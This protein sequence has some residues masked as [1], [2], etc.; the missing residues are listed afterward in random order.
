M[1]RPT[2]RSRRDGLLYRACA[3]ASLD[4][5]EPRR[6]LASVGIV[7]GVLT[8]NADGTNDVINI[9]PIAGGKV[10]VTLNGGNT[11][12][13]ATAFAKI[14]VNANGGNDKVSVSNFL[15]KPATL[16]G[17]PGNDTLGGGGANDVL[18][19]GAGADLIKG[20]NG[21]DTVDYSMRTKPL[22]LGLGSIADDGETGEHDNLST[23]LETILG[24]SAGDGI[25]TR[26]GNQRIVGGGG[27]DLIDTGNGND[28]VD[29]GAGEDTIY[30]QAGNDSILGGAGND[31][32]DAGAGTDFV[33]AQAD[34]G[35][36]FN[37]ENTAGDDW[38]IALGADG[39]LRITGT[40]RSEIITAHIGGDAIIR[41]NFHTSYAVKSFSAAS[42]VGVVLHGNG[43]DDALATNAPR[44]TITGG[45][46]N[47][48]INAGNGPDSIDGG[49]GNDDITTENGNDTVV[50]G[51]GNDSVHAGGGRDSVTGG[52]GNDFLD[53]GFDND[54]IRGGNGD[55]LIH[56]GVGTDSVVGDAGSDFILSG[57]GIGGTE[58]PIKMS[59]GTMTILGSNAADYIFLD[60][61][62]ITYNGIDIW[63]STLP[64]TV[65]RI[66]VQARGGNDNVAMGPD[67]VPVTLDGGDGNDWLAGGPTG[68]SILG[69][70]GNDTLQG[71]EGNDT[72]L[73]GAG[74]D[75]ADG[76]IYN[77]PGD[78]IVGGDG[79][80]I[81]VNADNPGGNESPYT[82]V[83]GVLTIRGRAAINDQIYAGNIGFDYNGITIWTNAPPATRIVILGLGGDDGLQIEGSTSAQLEGGDGNDS[84]WGGSGRNTVLGGNG[85]DSV[86]GGPLKDTIDGGAGTDTLFI[87]AGGDVLTS[88]E[89]SVSS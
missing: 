64:A 49:A 80:D 89:A 83:N 31:F 18:D 37:A 46:G 23:D 88:I 39:I 17:G 30:S 43:G 54:T 7:G 20:G 28:T 59:G 27:N 55:D 45:D 26:D 69:G 29:A 22:Q 74:D 6:L 62:R 47:D 67:F 78:S 85:N 48:S 21:N 75:L 71:G 58:S 19:G 77:D 87:T 2:P 14:L 10:R 16:K 34:G 32:I 1:R 53:G 86:G 50:G 35:I 13:I 68:D 79:D 42:V 11:D 36:V 51:F 8:V 3:C 70:N 57:E 52:D 38:R 9:A 15:T 61:F 84:L 25:T 72:L 81:S 41:V 40:D 33:D 73:G 65:E 76:G 4:P 66:V 24:G 12:F 82:L 5:L 60:D 56:G 44:T 63:R